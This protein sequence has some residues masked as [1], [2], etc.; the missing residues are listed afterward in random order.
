MEEGGASL[1]SLVEFSV[2]AYFGVYLL[3]S[4]LRIR[5]QR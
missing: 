2:Y 1:F 4:Q 5:Q 3:L